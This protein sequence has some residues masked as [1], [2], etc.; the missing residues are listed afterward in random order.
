MTYKHYRIA[1]IFV[2]M[3]LAMII[4]QATILNNYLLAAAAITIAIGVNLILRN[5]VKEIIAD[6]RDYQIAGQA[7]RYALITFG[8]L[9]ALL[10][11]GFMFLRQVNPLYETIGSTIAYTVCLLMLFYSLIFTYLNKTMTPSKKIRFFIVV[12]LL[13]IFFIIGSLRLFSGSEDVWICDN[14]QWVKHGQPSS[15]MP[16]EECR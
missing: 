9:A 15:Q 2:A 5:R 7:A 1:K 8:I 13:V 11:L 16:Q 4:S 14:G 3:F 12:A 6:E 10:S